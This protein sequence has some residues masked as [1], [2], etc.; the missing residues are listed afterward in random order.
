[1]RWACLSLRQPAGTAAGPRAE[2][3]H[4]VCQQ[5]LRALGHFQQHSSRLVV[6]TY[7]NILNGNWAFKAPVL[8]KL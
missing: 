4:K 1:M 5:L 2:V 6:K 3:W 7:C 8:A